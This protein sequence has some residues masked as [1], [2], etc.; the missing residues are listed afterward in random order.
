MKSNTNKNKTT[1]TTNAQ[2]ALAE[3]NRQIETLNQQRVALAQPLK[4][5][6]AQMRGELTALENEVRQLDPT[7]KPEPMKAKAE[8]KIAEIL[9]ANGQPMTPEEIVHAVGDAFSSWKVKNTLKKKS[10]GAKAVF[11]LADGKYSVKAAAA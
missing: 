6:Y 9:T 8:T 1:G 10:T 5:R 3:I 2:T 4:D 7:W 11:T